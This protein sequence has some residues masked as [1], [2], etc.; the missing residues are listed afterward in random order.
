[1]SPTNETRRRVREHVHTQPGIHFNALVRDSEFAPGQIQY[2]IR[3]LLQ[4]EEVTA[5]RLYGRTHYYPPIH[6]VWER[7]TLALARRETAREVLAHLLECEGAKPATV[8]D[9]LGIAR[10]TLEWHLDRLCEQG[11]VEKKR[12]ERNRVTLLI[13]H[14][15]RT[16]RLLAETTD[17]LPDRFA[18]RFMRLVDELFEE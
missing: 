7:R 3:R 12:D 11:I 4:A 15:D 6:D 14:P 5:E 18:D 2:H 13:S 9:S 1:M 8:A 17:S 16:A 10:S